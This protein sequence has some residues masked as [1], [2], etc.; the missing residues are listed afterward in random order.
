MKPPPTSFPWTRYWCP[1]GSRP[2]LENEYL[3][4]PTAPAGWFAPTQAVN[5]ATLPQLGPVPCLILLGDPGSGKSHEIAAETLRLEKTNLAQFTVRRLD[6]KLRTESL[7]EKEVF[8]REEFIGWTQGRHAL[9]L[10]FDSMDECWRRVP[11]LGPVILAAIEP[12]LKKKLPPLYLRLGCRAAEW[13]PEIERDLRAAFGESKEDEKVQVWELAPLTRDDVRAAATASQL[14]AGK[15]LT[16]VGEREVN[17]FAARPITLQMLLA[18]ANEGGTLGRDRAEIYQKGCALLCRDHHQADKAAPRL[19]TTI[20]ERLACAGYLAT[21]AVLSN[22]Y[23]IF[24]NAEERPADVNGVIALADVLGQKPLLPGIDLEFDR[25]TFLETLHTGLFDAQAGGLYSWHHQSY[26]EYLAANYLQSRQ[27]PAAEIVQS[28]CD[29]TSGRPRLWP[30]MEETACWLATLLSEVFNLLVGSNAEVFVRCDPARLGPDQRSQI[31][32]GYLKLVRDREAEAADS[33]KL[34]RLAHPDLAKQLEPVLANSAEDIFVRDLA[35][36]IVDACEVRELTALLIRLMLDLNEEERLRYGAAK[37]LSDWADDGIRTAIHAQLKPEVLDS[38][39]VRGCVLQILWPGTLSDAELVTFLSE[40]RHDNYVGAYQRFLGDHLPTS[41]GRA[42]L[43]P[44]LQWVRSVDPRPDGYVRDPFDGACH[45]VLLAAFRSIAKPPV[46][47]EF[48]LVVAEQTRRDGVLF[49]VEGRKPLEEIELRKVFWCELIAGELPVR[50]TIVGA[51]LSESGLTHED[52]YDWVM[53]ELATADTRQ[54]SRW[55]ELAFWL[56]QP[57]SRPEQISRMMPMA[58][59]DPEVA[60]RMLIYTSSPL[61][62]RNGEPNWRKDDHYR[63]EKREAELASR[64][65]FKQQIDEALTDYEGSGKHNPIWWLIHRLTHPVK[66]FD[67][68]G[69]NNMSDIGWKHLT[70]VQHARILALTPRFISETQVNPAEVYDPEK[71]YRSYVAGLAFMLELEEAGSTWPAEQTAA[72][73]AAWSQ[74]MIQYQDRVHHVEDPAWQR[75]FAFAFAKAKPAFLAALR[76]WL[77]NRGDRHVPLKRFESLPIGTDADLEDVFLTSAT[78]AERESGTEFEFFGFL[79]RHKSVRTEAVLVTW[80]PVPGAAMHEKASFADALLLCFRPGVY[81]NAV[82]DRIFADVPWGRKVFPHLGHIGGI[83]SSWITSIDVERLVRTWE[84]LD[85]EYPGNPYDD[86]RHD[87]T[88]TFPH[89]VYMF[90]SHLLSFIEKHGTEEAVDALG[91]LVRRNPE[92]PWLGQVLARARHIMRRESWAA[93]TAQSTI[94]YLARPGTPPLSND[95][96]L[97]DA[98]LASL[99]RYQALLKG[100]TPLTE[101]WNEPAG[102][103]KLWVPKDEKNFSDC[104]ARH[105]ER[106]LRLHQINVARESEIRQ[107]TGAAPGD[108]PDLMVTAPSASDNGMKLTVAVEVKCTWNDDVVTSIE[109]QLLNRYLRGLRC[110]IH[111]SA[112]FQCPSWSEGD[113]RRSRSLSSKSL[114]EVTALLRNE[115]DRL[116]GTTGKRLD[117][118]V[119]DAAI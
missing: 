79:L 103:A 25:E 118:I 86:D 76:R 72:F 11:E 22:R 16:E 91:G 14:D 94:A 4:S 30:Q 106:D 3:V 70:D 2:T 110:G 65:P 100:P 39:D 75:L 61:I 77:D 104:L 68:P 81:G 58:D 64:K 50:N 84:W 111:V 56:F 32:T 93:P 67:E 21:V 102:P 46:R 45:A 117:A 43:V 78:Q 13:R 36:D 51:S 20:Q 99:N 55:L 26:A 34:R 28:L 119:I 98:L 97:A 87:G 19:H 5:L 60:E 47:T 17:A 89:E 8:A 44:F 96:D 95:A 90:R 40:P 35:L 114:Q 101:L 33:D 108:E 53:D 31:V 85:R 88:V 42:D 66:D 15:F 73:W 116:A 105:F 49:K 57:T 62:E 23:L 109:Q 112:H 1:R 71:Y 113:W 41:L 18:T 10:F 24:G 29:T 80:Q 83:Y 107:Q 27:I 52:D 7:I 6:L 12:H 74:V 37:A 38:D 9:T 63:R 82:L 115:R 69:G 92:L 59:A 48:M 54:R